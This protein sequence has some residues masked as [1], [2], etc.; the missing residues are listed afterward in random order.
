MPKAF[1]TQKSSTKERIFHAALRLFS[2]Q[3]FKEVSMRDIAKEVGIS[4]S[5]LYNHYASKDD[6]L[7]SFYD[8]YSYQWNKARPDLDSLVARA[9]VEPVRDILMRTDFRFDPEVDETMDQIMKI[10]LRQ[11]MMD[12][13]SEQ[14][15]KGHVMFRLSDVLMPLMDRLIE[16]GLIQETNTRALGNLLTLY[17]IGAML[18]NRTSLQLGLDEW[19]DGL[20]LALSLVKPVEHKSASEG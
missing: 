9:K 18:L 2:S 19:R 12:A 14:F 15:F 8:Y 11:F 6:L 17:S 5:S 4:V 16:Q 1:E 20:E 10:A 3:G 7:D 13:R